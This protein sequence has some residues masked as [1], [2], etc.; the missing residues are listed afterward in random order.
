LAVD[1]DAGTVTCL[2]DDEAGLVLPAGEEASAGQRGQTRRCVPSGHVY[3]G[4]RAVGCDPFD[5][6][7]VCRVLGGQSD[8]CGQTGGTDVAEADQA[9]A[10]DPVTVD[11]GGPERRR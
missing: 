4:D 7:A 3:A 10:R 11:E 5:R 2:V 6:D 1:A 8:R 9:D